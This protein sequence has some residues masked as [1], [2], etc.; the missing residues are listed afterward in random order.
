MLLPT[1]LVFE[2]ASYTTLNINLPN[3]FDSQ[4]FYKYFEIL[5]FV[6]SNFFS[7]YLFIRFVI[8]SNIELLNEDLAE[9]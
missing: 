6:C 4:F 8:V 2:N 5:L 7:S 9:L 3:E 1:M